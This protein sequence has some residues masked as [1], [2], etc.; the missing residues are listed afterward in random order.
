MSTA[1]VPVH[2]AT[3]GDQ[4]AMGQ[5]RVTLIWALLVL[6]SLQ[7]GGVQSP[8]YIPTRME[9][10]GTALALMLALALALSSNWRVRLAPVPTF[11]LA[12]IL[13]VGALVPSVAGVT[14]A[15][16]VARTVRLASVVLAAWLLVPRIVADRSL[17][18]RA[19]F[20]V[21]AALT[22]AIMV[23][24]LLLP[25]RAF[26][27]SLGRL[28]G[29]IPAITAPRVGE[30]AGVT[31]G[32]AAILGV[33]RFVRARTAVVVFA[34]GAAGV[35]LSHTRTA[36]LAFAIGSIAALLVA[37]QTRGAARRALGLVLVLGPALFLATSGSLTSWFV[38]GQSGEMWTSL[39]GR[40]TVWPLVIEGQPPGL[41]V[42]FGTG[43]SS[44]T[45]EGRPID[46]GWV[47]TYHEQGLLAIA[48]VAAMFLVLGWSIW[49][50]RAS[51]FS[52]VA[53][54]LVVFVLVSTVTETGISDASPYLVHLLVAAL[55]VSRTWPSTVRGGPA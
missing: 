53:A 4:E 40:R 22:T 46:N 34:A 20:T 23:E 37:A 17:I 24:A 50:C 51:A 38:R 43:L 27:P 48:V 6:S 52:A 28:S 2:A 33:L 31:A 29:V 25:S 12:S 15:G 45:F 8:F 32:L 55:L 14:G 11:V 36:T 7:W 54:F 9:Q 18:V 42:W 35:I 44:K 41:A 30:I 3:S 21:Y 26:E 13:I 5:R 49:R 39:S 47:A 10:A 1:T 19:H 16:T